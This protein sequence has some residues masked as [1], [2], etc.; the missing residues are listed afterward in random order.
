M[1]DS[2]SDTSIGDV[3]RRRI[4]SGNGGGWWDTVEE[5]LLMEYV[6]PPLASLGTRWPG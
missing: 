1:A 5:A 6:A 2:A 3:K 4:P